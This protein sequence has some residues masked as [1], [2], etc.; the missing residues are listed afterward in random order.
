MAIGGAITAAAADDAGAGGLPTVA[1][2]MA[3]DTDETE[4]AAV[5]TT[6]NA[7]W[8]KPATG[9]EIRGMVGEVKKT[10]MAPSCQKA[11]ARQEVDV[12]VDV[13]EAD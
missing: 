5:A 2:A 13:G 6:A 7:S 11:A 12:S 8:R 4:I 3:G 10:G 1:C 9:L